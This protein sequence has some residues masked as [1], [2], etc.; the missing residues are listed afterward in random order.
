[1]AVVPF[2]DSGWKGWIMGRARRLLLIGFVLAAGAGGPLVAASSAGA[3]FTIQEFPTT[4]PNSVPTSIALGADGNMWFTER[5]VGKI[6]R[7]TPSGSITEYSVGI[8]GS[9]PETIT[10]G[11]DGNLWFTDGGTNAIGRITTSGVVTEF[12]VLTPSADPTGIATGTGGKL[13]FTEYQANQVGSITTS[14]VVK[15]YPLPGANGFP[16]GIT[17]GPDGNMWF[18]S[19]GN[20]DRITPKGAIKEFPTGISGSEPDNITAASDGD[21]WFTDFG[22]FAIGRMTT[23][24]VAT[25]F[26]V[27]GGYQPFDIAPAAD[28]DLWFTAS[29]SEVGQIATSGS[30][31]SETQDPTASAEPFGIAAGGDGNIWFTEYFGNAIGRLLLPNFNLQDIYY[32]PNHF[33]VPNEAG[34]VNQGETVTWLMLNPGTRGV[35]D[36]SGMDLYGA[37]GPTGG[38][39]PL[40]IDQTFSFTFD[41][42][43]GYRYD[44]P[45][46]SNSRGTVQVPIVVQP[47]VGTTGQAQVTWASADAPGGFAFDVQVKP[48]HASAFENW[49]TGVTSLG[50]VFGSSLPQWVGPGRYAFRAALIQ[51]TTGAASNFSPGMSIDLR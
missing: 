32:V 15:E 4:T 29:N 44:D 46:H 19:V 26:A 9:A 6:G 37:A 11:P 8:S 33:F 22:T 23:S 41:W 28:G 34:L 24:G 31:L 51:E 1:M 16:S 7:I 20:I 5:M 35:M 13:W 43:G 2:A 49:M 25:E 38:P 14:G 40:G 42:A 36:A 45:F 30:F 50:G 21:L 3:S 39:M 47:V 48:P 27:P 17:A 12:P 18:T 10:A